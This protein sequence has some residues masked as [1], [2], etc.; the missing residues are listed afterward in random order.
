MSTKYLS[1][2]TYLPIFVYGTLRTGEYNWERL[3]K[4]RTLSERPAI[5]PGHVMYAS[6]VPCVTEGEGS[7]VGNLVE[8]D[9]SIYAEVLRDLDELEEFDPAA[10]AGWYLR[11]ARHV[12]VDG[13]PVLAWIY[14][15]DPTTFSR[16]QPVAHVPD[17]DWV[18]WSRRFAQ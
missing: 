15:G 6:N 14:H 8:I 1:Y 9:Q 4:G 5:A 10:G 11:V 17:G 2:S 18:A 3:L 13:Q 16:D 12:L 7:V